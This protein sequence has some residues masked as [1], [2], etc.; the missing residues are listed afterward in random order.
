MAEIAKSERRGRL[1]RGARSPIIAPPSWT[2]PGSTGAR[3]RR[4]QGRPRPLHGDRRQAGAR[5]GDRQ[6][7]SAPTSTRSTRPTS[8]R[9]NLFGIFVTQSL[10][11]P[12]ARTCPICCRAA[13]ACPSANITSRPTR[14]W[15]RSATP[16]GRSSRRCWARPGSTTPRRGP[17]ASTISKPRSPR[18][19]ATIARA[20]TAPRRNNPWSQADFAKKAPGIDWAAFF[21]AAQLSTVPTIIAWH[22]EPTRKLAALVASEPLDAWKDWLAFHQ[23]NQQAPCSAERDAR[24]QLS[25][26]TARR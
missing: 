9:E 2:R 17:S 15:P 1:Q 16:I 21:Q 25:P 8:R 12:V 24:R 10:A 20:R 19:H 6:R 5:L 14:R 23:I 22:A 7:P 3:L 18:A 26:S 11:E 4:A 13:S